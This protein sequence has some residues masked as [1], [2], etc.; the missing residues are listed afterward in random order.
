M[1]LSSRV[2]YTGD[3]RNIKKGQHKECSILRVEVWNIRRL[4]A[5]LKNLKV[6]MSQLELD[7]VGIADYTC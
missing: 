1:M 5:K 6:E 2:K 7:I 4:R 3:R